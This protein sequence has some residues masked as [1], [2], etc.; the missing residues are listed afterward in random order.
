VEVR[1]SV[2]GA[3]APADA[4]AA[5]GCAAGTARPSAAAI[6]EVGSETDPPSPATEPSAA[7]PSESLELEPKLDASASVP[8]CFPPFAEVCLLWPSATAVRATW[9]DRT[10]ANASVG[11][12]PPVG[13]LVP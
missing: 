8:L 2:A 4:G 10:L 9:F 6:S 13:G 12:A 11:G 5:A 1:A 3:L 7:L